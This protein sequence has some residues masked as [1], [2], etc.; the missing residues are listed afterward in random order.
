MNKDIIIVG[1]FHEIIELCEDC[2]FIIVGIIDNKIKGNYY[3][4]PILGTDDDRYK[5]RNEHPECK[6]VISPDVPAVRT[7]LA[8]LYG[9]S[10]FEFATVISPKSR[11]S[12]SAIIGVGTVI[13]DGVNV[14]SGT[15]IGDFV[16][17][18]TRA[19]VMH[20]NKV[21][22]YV[23][24]APNAVLLGYVSV[25]NSAYIGANSTILPN[26]VIGGAA[27]VGAGSVVTKNVPGHKTVKGVPA[28]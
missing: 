6:V 9:E 8:K 5:V 17:V 1:A 28:K 20:D 10:G 15:S 7:K 25:G 14:S 21:E 27:M 23:T 4:Y 12:R 3:G 19:N 13:Q 16:K 26:I 24:I 2:G 22:D 18:N 11:I